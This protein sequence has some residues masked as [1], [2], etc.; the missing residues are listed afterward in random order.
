[1]GP[2]PAG[3]GA[4]VEIGFVPEGGTPNGLALSGWGD[5]GAGGVEVVVQAER[6]G[7][8]VGEGA[9]REAGV[10]LAFVEGIGDDAGESVGAAATGDGVAAADF[11]LAG[12]AEPAAL[13]ADFGGGREVEH[14]DFARA[15]FGESWEV[16]EDGDRGEGEELAM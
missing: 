6:L 11:D 5:A 4:V 13:D 8:E 12:L 10:G 1:V 9:E 15:D 2:A 7:I 16:V 3:G 14:V